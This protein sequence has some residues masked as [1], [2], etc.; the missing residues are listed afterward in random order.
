M[1]RNSYIFQ[2][3]LKKEVFDFNT[4]IEGFRE[5]CEKGA[6]KAGKLPEGREVK[7][8]NA[9]GMV[10]EWL[11]PAGA[12]REKVV[13]YVHGGGYAPAATTGM[14]VPNSPN[15]PG[16]PICC[17]NTGWHP[18]IPFPQPWKIPWLFINGCSIRA[19]NQEISWWQGNQPVADCALP[20][21]WP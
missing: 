21:C 4:S 7:R 14:W 9:A 10:A 20:P 19:I 6:S 1:V 15:K 18:S 5:R 2:G 3:R 12:D 8:G 17:M 13:L 16:I 11:I